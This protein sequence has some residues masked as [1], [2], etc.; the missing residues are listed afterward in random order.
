MKKKTRLKIKKQVS[1]ELPL[2]LEANKPKKAHHNK[3]TKEWKARELAKQNTKRKTYDKCFNVPVSK[4]LMKDG[5]RL[6]DL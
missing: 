4:I 1:E 2:I 5:F 6:K 3:L